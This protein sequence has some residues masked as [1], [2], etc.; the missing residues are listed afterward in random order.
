MPSCPNA[1]LS[2]CLAGPLHLCISAP[3]FQCFIVALSHCSAVSTHVPLSRY[4]AVSLVTL[5]LPNSPIAPVPEFHR[6]TVLLVTL[7]LSHDCTVSLTNSHGPTVP[8][9]DGHTVQTSA[10]FH[11]PRVLSSACLTAHLFH[12]ITAPLPYCLTASLPD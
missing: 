2:Q 6:F 5:Q 10:L 4:V 9:S 12:W 3:K 1:Q 11:C 8:L 7:S